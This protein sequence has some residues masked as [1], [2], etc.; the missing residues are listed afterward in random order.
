MTSTNI[1]YVDT[2]FELSVLTKV[3]GEP[4]Y[5]KLKAIKNELKSNA[6]TVTSDLGGGTHGHLGLVLTAAEYAAI[7]A[8]PYARPAH[9]GPLTIPAGTAQHEALRLRNEHKEQIRLFRETIDVEKALIKQVVAALESKYL[10]S[11]RDTN[12]NS[13]IR[14][15]SE[16]LTHLFN[17]Y[18]RVDAES[19]TELEGKVKDKHYD[20]SEPIVT[21]FNEIEELA[22]LG[23]A[24]HNP[25]SN[26]Q[27]VQF[28]KGNYY[29]C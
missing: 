20:V 26:M 1:N 12:S 6:C 22:R 10:E 9:P 28:I 2:Y 24:A 17:R 7:S 27:K 19:L 14:P 5:E 8:T 15:L 13:I 18:G 25:Y 3:H 21:I 23:D 4:T 29:Y 11:L 16:V